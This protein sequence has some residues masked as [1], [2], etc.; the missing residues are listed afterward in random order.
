[1]EKLKRLGFYKELKHV[2]SEISLREDVGR[3]NLS[4]GDSQKTIEYLR[5][6]YVLAISASYAFDVLSEEKVIIDSISILTDG[7]WVWSNDYIYYLEKYNLSLPKDFI[8]YIRKIDW[9]LPKL[10]HEDVILLESMEY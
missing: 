6:G 9:I 7:E 2:S 4:V 3:N 10:S 8:N 1:M 5:S